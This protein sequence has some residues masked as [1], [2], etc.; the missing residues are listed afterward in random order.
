MKAAR[1]MVDVHC[2]ILA[3]MDDGPKSF[4]ESV[5]M[6]EAAV[7]EGITHV[8][9]TPHANS[10]HEFQFGAA[11]RAAGELQ[12]AIGDKLKLATGCDFHLSP[13]NLATLKENAKPFCVNQKEWLLVEFNDYSIPPAMDQTL[14]EL[15]L[16]GLRPIITHP[17]RNAIIRSQ[18]ERLERWI[19]NG[20]VAQVTAGSLVG[21][22]GP[23]A[24]ET[25]IAW[26]AQGLAHLVASDAHDTKRRPHKWREAYEVVKKEFGEA[27]AQ[28]LFAENPL[29]VF[30]GRELPHVPEIGAGPAKRKRFLFF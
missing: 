29:A 26:I 6:A 22:F 18:P 13:E 11:Q 27:G 25:G 4:E 20:C 16:D 17:E 15:R 5:A 2:H 23:N 19:R 7:R 3:G 30:E 28:V 21:A 12:K 24:Q 14:Y 8:V 1:T 10:T 9:A